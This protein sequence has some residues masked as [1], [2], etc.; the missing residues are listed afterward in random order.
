MTVQDI[1]RQREIVADLESERDLMQQRID[2]SSLGLDWKNRSDA[3]NQA[4]ER[5]KVLEGG[6]REDGIAEYFD[7]GTTKFD[8]GDVRI[9]KSYNFDTNLAREW[10]IKHDH[11]ELFKVNTTEFVKVAKAVKLDF[12]ETTKKPTFYLSKDLSEFLNE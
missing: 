5:L 11:F 8:G 12:L 4:K 1:A 7:S 10:I 9:R 6:Y 2:E 3:V